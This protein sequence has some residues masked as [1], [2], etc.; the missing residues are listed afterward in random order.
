ME[1]DARHSV[2]NIASSLA[3]ILGRIYQ[4]RSRALAR[5]TE[6]RS[7]V[8]IAVLWKLLSRLSGR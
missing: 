4:G 8:P 3:K 7:F 2:L 5:S 1:S 6:L